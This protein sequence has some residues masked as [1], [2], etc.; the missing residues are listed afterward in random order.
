MEIFQRH[1]VVSAKSQTEWAGVGAVEMCAGLLHR[2]LGEITQ[3]PD[4]EETVSELLAFKAVP[5][6][7]REQ[8]EMVSVLLFPRYKAAKV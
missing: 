2:P 6:P 8:S 3:P 1:R 7:A 4:P 5:G